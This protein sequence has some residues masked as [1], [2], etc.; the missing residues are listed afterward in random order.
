M[1]NAAFSIEELFRFLDAGVSAFHSTAAA[2]AILEAE[3]YVNCPESAAWELAP[4]GK[5]PTLKNL[6]FTLYQGQITAIMGF[7]GAGK[8]TLMNLLGGLTQTQQ[9]SML[10]EGKPVA[11]TQQDRGFAA[12][13]A[14]HYGSRRFTGDL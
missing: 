13:N 7:N 1:K 3:G 8:S 9:G 12:F 11:F 10:L 4:G 14:A 6:Q 5:E 2:S